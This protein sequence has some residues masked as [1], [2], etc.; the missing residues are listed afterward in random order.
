TTCPHAVPSINPTIPRSS[1]FAATAPRAT[2]TTPT[3]SENSTPTPNASPTG[4]MKT[5]T[6]TSTSTT[7]TTATPSTTRNT[8]ETP[9]VRKQKKRPSTE[10]RPTSN[11]HYRSRTLHQRALVN[12]VKFGAITSIAAVRA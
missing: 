1:T 6:S 7:T 3:A 12:I 8:C 11:Q 9:C 4:S 2:T 5:A 10:G